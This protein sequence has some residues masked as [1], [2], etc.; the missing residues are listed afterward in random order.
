MTRDKMLLELSV[1]RKIFDDKARAIPAASLD[2][3]VPVLGRSAIE[4]VAHVAAYDRLVAERLA[5]GRHG[6]S[7]N[8]EAD[9]DDSGAFEATTWTLYQGRRPEEILTSSA[10]DYNSVFHQVGEL[11]DEELDAPTGKTASLDPAWLD[12][13]APWEAIAADTW[14][15]YVQHHDDLDAAIQYAAGKVM[16]GG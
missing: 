6:A 7:T 3:P 16:A 11:S 12:G 2:E 5:S 10:D 8:L 15:H 9:R 1:A 4:I 14:M 13:R